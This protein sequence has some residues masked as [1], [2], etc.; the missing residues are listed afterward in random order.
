MKVRLQVLE[1]FHV[2]RHI[3]ER[4]DRETDVKKLI[5]LFAILQTPKILSR[6]LPF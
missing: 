5:V 2:D 6:S 3:D 1:L 4:T